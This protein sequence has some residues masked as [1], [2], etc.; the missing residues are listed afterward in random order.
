MSGTSSRWRSI[1]TGLPGST[2]AEAERVVQRVVPLSLSLSVGSGWPTPGRG[3][4]TGVTDSGVQLGMELA[5]QPLHRVLDGGGESNPLIEALAGDAI[6]HQS[7]RQDVELPGQLNR[8]GHAKRMGGRA[9]EFTRDRIP[10]DVEAVK[11]SGLPAS[12]DSVYDQCLAGTL[13]G[14]EQTFGFSFLV[15]DHHTVRLGAAQAACDLKPRSVV[16]MP[17]VADADQN[18]LLRFRRETVVELNVVRQGD[19]RR[20]RGGTSSINFFLQVIA[21]ALHYVQDGELVIEKA[22]PVAEEVRINGMLCAVQE[23]H[24]ALAHTLLSPL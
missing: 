18:E 4:A 1:P 11:G 21:V 13:P 2:S 9:K 14:R 17:P 24:R 12:A 15:A 19:V 6:D 20:S 22:P 5:H 23:M 3:L 10:G 8:I 16:V 7:R